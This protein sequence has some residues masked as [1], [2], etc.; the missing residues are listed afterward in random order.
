MF[1]Y[2]RTLTR[3]DL[4]DYINSHYKAPRMVLAAAGGRCSPSSRTRWRHVV[5]AWEFSVSGVWLCVVLPLQVWTTVSWFRWPSLTSVVCL[6]STRETPSLCCHHADSQA[7]RWDFD[8]DLLELVYYTCLRSLR[9]SY[10]VFPLFLSA[11]P[12]ISMRDDAL[13]LA[14]V[15]IAVEGASAASPDI[16]PL[17]VA[18]AIIGSYDITYGGGKVGVISIFCRLGTTDG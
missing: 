9:L 1:N 11:S 13:P 4:V 7:V 12:Q 5:V 8:I 16:V 15:A 18:N 3:Q 2:S 6:L 10:C 17:M 14:H